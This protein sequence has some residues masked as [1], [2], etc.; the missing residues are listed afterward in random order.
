MA[1]VLM[2]TV[3]K[4][5]FSGSGAPNGY[6][7]HDTGGALAVMAIQA[8]ALGMHIHA[9]AGFD[10]RKAQADLH[11]PQDYE[12]AAA[13]ALGY[14]G[15][16]EILPPTLQARELAKRERKPLSEIAFN[17]VWDKPLTF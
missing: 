7:M 14:A 4:K 8:T 11:I 5:N 13:V 9:M 2:I 1:P 10:R 15:S 16:P 6:A 12:P 17:G 3:A